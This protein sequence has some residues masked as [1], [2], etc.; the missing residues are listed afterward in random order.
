M[1]DQLDSEF[2]QWIAIAIRNCQFLVL[3]K[4]NLL[5]KIFSLKLFIVGIVSQYYSDSEEEESSNVKD[6]GKGKLELI[7]FV[8]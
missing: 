3:S 7:I 6:S 5:L 2:R 8:F 1:F 4:T